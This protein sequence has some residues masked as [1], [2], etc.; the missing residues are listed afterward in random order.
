MI[1][2]SV[3]EESYQKIETLAQERGLTPEQFVEAIA[4][5]MLDQEVDAETREWLN[6]A[7]AMDAVRELREADA[8]DKPITG[9]PWDQFKAEQ[10]W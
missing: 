8:Q 10:G 9:K 2:I 7:E 6:D 3:S 4:S 1:Q 5:D